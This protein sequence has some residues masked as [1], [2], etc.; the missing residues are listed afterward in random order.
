MFPRFNVA[1]VIWARVGLSIV[2]RFP[3]SLGHFVRT[4]AMSE[5]LPPA[6]PYRVELIYL[7][8]ISRIARRDWGLDS[9]S[10][11]THS[12]S[13]CFVYARWDSCLPNI[14]SA[15]NRVDFGGHGSW[16]SVLTA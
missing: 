14:Y 15:I 4:E 7:T 11:E 2:L 6:V 13:S 12:V 16:S 10:Y 5:M 9:S 3:A 8:G 1:P